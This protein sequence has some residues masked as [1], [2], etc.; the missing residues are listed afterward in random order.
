M[1]RLTHAFAILAM[2]TILIGCGRIAFHD[3]PDPSSRETGVLFYTPKPY[4]LVSRVNAKDAP[5]KVDVIYVNDLSKP[6]YAR[7]H[8]GIGSADLSMAFSNG[9][10]SSFGQKTDPKIAETL[11]AIGGVVTAGGGLTTALATAAKTRAEAGL[12]REQALDISDGHKLLAIA[13]N[14][15]NA[16]NNP[17]SQILTGNEKQALISIQSQIHAIGTAIVTPGMVGPALNSVDATLTGILE[18]WVNAIRG[19]TAVE[20]AA[21]KFLAGITT[22]RE[23]LKALVVKSKPAAVEQP[24]VTLYEVDNSSGATILREVPFKPAGSADGALH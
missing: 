24:T 17:L 1:H 21:A 14:L 11:T 13:T 3:G 18:L 12:L 6:T 8:P 4:I 19:P 20:G 7:A 9:A 15:R 10:L 23:E 16:L 5:I 2:T 22:L